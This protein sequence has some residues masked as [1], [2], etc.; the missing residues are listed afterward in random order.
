MWGVESSFS[1]LGQ[2][3]W[4]L[5]WKKDR[6]RLYNSRGDYVSVQ[7]V[8]LCDCPSLF[9]IS[10]QAPLPKNGVLLSVEKYLE[11]KLFCSK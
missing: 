5:Q 2:M 10:I 9:N 11:L 6:S 7:T 8:C 1:G 4:L 3:S